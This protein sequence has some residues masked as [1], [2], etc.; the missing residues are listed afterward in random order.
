MPTTTQNKRVIHTLD[1][2]PYAGA[3]LVVGAT[4][5][6]SASTDFDGFSSG[7][8]SAGAASALLAAIASSIAVSDASDAKPANPTGVVRSCDIGAQSYK[9]N[10]ATAL[11][12]GAFLEA[13][14]RGE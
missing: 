4:A 9:P 8:G 2:C 5:L 14:E 1:D 3:G 12:C 6:A 13:F 7:V 11:L 10:F